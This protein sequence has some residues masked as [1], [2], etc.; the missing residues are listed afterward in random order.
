MMG[1][2]VCLSC[3]AAAAACVELRSELALP[4]AG[5]ACVCHSFPSRLCCSWAVGGS[6]GRIGGSVP[7]AADLTGRDDART[8]GGWQCVSCTLD[9]RHLAVPASPT[10]ANHPVPTASHADYRLFLVRHAKPKQLSRLTYLETEQHDERMMYWSMKAQPANYNYCSRIP[11]LLPPR[12][13]RPPRPPSPSWT[14]C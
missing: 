14:T 2:S 5:R 1:V 3:A 8:N 10:T 11:P 6:T 7:A 12:P 4:C 13:P 9:Q